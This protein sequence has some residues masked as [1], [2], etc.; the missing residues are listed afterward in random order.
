MLSNAPKLRKKHNSSEASR[1]GVHLALIVICFIMCIPALYALQSATLTLEEAAFPPP[2]L[3]P[4]GNDLI[5]NIQ[6][7]FERLNFGTLIVNTVVVTFVVVIGKTALALLA[8]LAF[9]YFRFAGRQVL[10][11]VVLLTLLMP[12]EI[13]LLP[14]FRMT[15]ELGWGQEYPRLA[16]TIPFLGTATGAFLFRQHFQ[17]IP[18]EL[19]EAAQIDGATPLRFLVSVLLPMSG[20]VIVA[21]SLIQFISAWNQYLWPVLVVNSPSQQ[22]IQ[23]GVRSAATFGIATDYGVLMAAGLVASLPPLLLFVFLQK[24]FMSGFAITRDK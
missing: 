14:L 8:G 6:T 4:P 19:A 20:N 13:I 11:F 5:P 22:V 9:V 16:L 12:T 2:R 1:W 7:L 10:F 24:Q 15:S 3:F 23:V 21:H 18:R 17:N